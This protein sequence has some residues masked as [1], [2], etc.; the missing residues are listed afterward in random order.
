MSLFWIV[1][2]I[3][4]AAVVG[5]LALWLIPKVQVSGIDG[6]AAAV[7]FDKEN[8]ARKTIAQI[9]GGAV[10]LI[11][12]YFTWQQVTISQEGQITER[13]TRATDQIGSNTLE[14]RVGGIYAFQRIAVES[15]EDYGS[16]VQILT[17]FVREN[18]PR[19]EQNEKDLEGP[20]REGEQ[21]G[22]SEP[23]VF[24]EPPADIKAA[25]LSLVTIS[26]QYR[27][28]NPPQ[29]DLKG[30]NLEGGSLSGGEFERAVLMDTN[31]AGA[32]FVDANLSNAYFHDANLQGAQFLGTNLHGAT[33]LK[34]E[35][36]KARF[37]EADL[38]DA[39]E[40]EQEQLE[41]TIGDPKS[42]LLPE[43]LHAPKAWDARYCP[44]DY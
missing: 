24:S 8:E 23:P 20:Q 42:T 3:L 4:G 29:V 2:L 37:C 34:A 21:I 28:S 40:L 10:L 38:Q 13:F 11:G 32:S 44:E 22:F 36:S 30:T 18:A 25:L 6:D 27:S 26:Q 43:E 16:I 5:F 17:A 39:K 19:E 41:D 12:L 31:L 1:I 33:F 15:E 35:L 9:L 7:K 14:V